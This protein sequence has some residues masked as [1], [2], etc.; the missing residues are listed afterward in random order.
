MTVRR[1]VRIV[2]VTGCLLLLPAATWAQ[3][4]S[5]T[6]A[7]VV[8]DTSGAVMPGVTVEAA[9]PA[10][11]EKVRSVVSDD[12]GQYKIVNLVPG[13]YSV[14]FTLTGFGT[15]KRDGIELPPSFTATV[16]AELKVGTLEETVTV[17]GQ[18]PVVDTQNARQQT[19]V[20]RATLD[21][22][23]TTKRIGQ[24]ATIIPGATYASPTFQDVGGAGGEG[25]M[26]AVHG[27]R[28]TDVAVNMEGMNVNV[29]A[30]AIY[31]FNA[32][33]F[34]EVGLQTSGGSG[35]SISGGVQ[36][37]IVPKDGGN[38]F[39]GNLNGA[40]SGPSLQSSNLTPG[41]QARGLNATGGLKKSYDTGAALGGPV[42]K[43]RLWFFL[44]GRDWGAQSYASGVY[45]NSTQGTK[46]GTDPAWLVVPY[47]PDPSRRRA[48]DNKY[49]QDASL[50]L[51]WQAAQK[52]KIVFSYS[53]QNDCS[54][55]YGLIGQGAPAPSAPKVAPEALDD[56]LYNP[57]YLPLVSWSYPA[58]SRLLLEAGASAMIYNLNT[59]RL[60]ETGPTTLPITDL[61]TNFTWGSRAL[62]YVLTFNQN[63]MQRA[64]MSYVTGSHA[65]KAGFDLREINSSG[66]ANRFT[67]PNKI[68]GARDY[69][70]RDMVP[71]RV[72]IW[73][74]PT[75]AQ[76]STTALGIFAQDQWT[77]R[78][79]TLNL[80]VRYDQFQGSVPAQSLPAGPFVPARD[81]PAVSNDPSFKNLNP[82]LGAAYDLFGNG[83]T[84]LK[85]SLGRYMPIVSAATFNPATAQAANATRT[86][87][88]SFFG[89]GDPR[90][91]NFVPDCVLDASVPGVNG[92]C[93]RLSD[94]TFGQVKAG[95]TSYAADALSGFNKQFYNWQGSVS[96]QQQ[97]RPGMALNVGYFRTWYGGFLATDNTAVTAASFSSYC[98]TAPVDP[99][100]PGGGGNQLC[101]LYDVTPTLFGQVNN[102]VTLAS[103]YG[104]QTEVYNGVDVTLNARFGQ[105]GQFSGGLNVGRTV[106]D[107]CYTMGNPQLDFAG[108]TTGVLAPRSQAYCHISPPLSTGTQVKFLVVY[109]LPWGLQTSGTYQNTSG[110][111][112]TAADP[113]SSAQIAPS[114]GRN[115]SAGA[116][117]QNIIDLIPP[118]SLFEDRLQQLDFRVTR[119]FEIGKKVKVRANFDI[120]NLLNGSAIL[121]ANYG[122]GSLWLQPSQ[123]LGGRL[124]KFGGQLDF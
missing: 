48:F 70:F 44:S 64:S 23:P 51:T 30:V 78:K 61:A 101:G 121:A 123:I 17:S 58:T 4:A 14:T 106:T 82:R 16:N 87:N 28:T 39:S 8:K 21:A 98:I 95:N 68:I 65:F 118:N 81:F 109:P 113:I 102:V 52:H 76:N 41:L 31:S 26:F 92:E 91:G 43:D 5:A 25:G 84:A 74:V 93:G 94:Q 29:T 55:H 33:T 1:T 15:F 72:R 67:D 116:T 117:A 100:L 97:L 69:T 6:I 83:K 45:Y 119:R 60:P 111:P 46:L 59:H 10:L 34:Q 110:I 103:N 13:T 80:A 12:Q 85:V 2:V 86:W 36:V 3:V 9:S 112:V 49:Y 77:V 56:H 104:T 50:R 120:Y 107:N 32:Y 62:P 37:N 27:G 47:T 114:L 24:F 90:T 11:I 108:S 22:L 20:E 63:Y 66:G 115:L 7:G 96:V 42:K 88:D 105:G 79:L 54:C 53:V 18:A 38:T 71:V 35:E 75:G 99:R 89:P 122:Y 40:Y 124:F 57:D 19:T 73:S